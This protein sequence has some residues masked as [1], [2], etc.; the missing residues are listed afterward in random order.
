MTDGLAGETI[1]LVLE[2]GNNWQA[3]IQEAF[4]TKIGPTWSFVVLELYNGVAKFHHFTPCSESTDLWMDCVVLWI[5]PLTKEGTPMKNKVVKRVVK[6]SSPEKVLNG[7]TTPTATKPPAGPKVIRK[8][9]MAFTN[10]SAVNTTN[11]YPTSA[12]AKKST[13]E[14][15]LKS[16]ESVFHNNGDGSTDSGVS[17]TDSDNEK[18]QKTDEKFSDEAKVISNE[19]RET[20]NVKFVAANVASNLDRRHG[21]KASTDING[22][23]LSASFTLS[24]ATNCE[25]T[26]KSNKINQ[27]EK[28]VKEEEEPR[29]E[30]LKTS[31]HH[32]SLK[33]NFEINGSAFSLT[34]ITN[35][36]LNR[37]TSLFSSKPKTNRLIARSDR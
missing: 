31:N 16:R 37:S 7:T 22:N 35:G 24:L 12:E 15:F 34:G 32:Q 33:D 23:E 21:N 14:K 8:K 3:P 26:T 9:A 20:E 30:D 6:K 18:S 27:I 10:I 29:K 19:Q 25:I 1:H 2:G 17:L 5:V 36:S 11:A 13:S 4:N 28:I